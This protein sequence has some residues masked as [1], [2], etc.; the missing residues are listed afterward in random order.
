[1]A[2]ETYMFVKISNAFFSTQ[3]VSSNPKLRLSESEAREMRLITE[4]GD[5]D[6]I[7]DQLTCREWCRWGCCW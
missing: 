2:G 7:R 4:G 3:N 6:E 5:A 1:M